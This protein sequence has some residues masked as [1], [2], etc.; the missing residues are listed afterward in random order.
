MT[1]PAWYTRDVSRETLDKL[2]A[3][4]NLIRKWTARI[5]LVSMASRDQLE[6]R[7]IWDSA[8]IYT[9]EEGSWLDIGSGGG[10]PAVVV[11]VLRAGE[12]RGVAMTLVESDQ[13][14][15]TFLR[16]CARELDLSFTVQAERVEILAPHAAGV[17]SARALAPLEG[18]LGYADRHLK[19]GGQCIFMKGAAWKEEVAQAQQNW[20]FSYDA[21]VSKTDANAAILRI[22]EI[23]RV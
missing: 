4:A 16:T 19:N 3:Y 21:T 13:R 12:G 2:Q 11:A 6:T 8:Q 1:P 15:A 23:E 9:G 14:K 18:L 7:H 10:L 5:N 17:L 20:R 22:K